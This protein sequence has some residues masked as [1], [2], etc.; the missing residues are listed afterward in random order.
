MSIGDRAIRRL[1]VIH[2]MY[3]FFYRK[4]TALETLSPF[5]I[6]GAIA[7]LAHGAESLLLT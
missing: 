1:T 5:V 7:A 2:A 3:S 4:P 6:T